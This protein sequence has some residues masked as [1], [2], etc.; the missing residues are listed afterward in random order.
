MLGWAPPQG[1]ASSSA[2]IRLHRHGE[3]CFIREGP[4]IPSR[5]LLRFNGRT[6]PQ[7]RNHGNEGL[8]GPWGLL[9]GCGWA[10]PLGLQTSHPW[11]E[12]QWEE[13]SG[14]AFFVFAGAGCD[15]DVG[16]TPEGHPRVW[17]GPGGGWWPRHQDG[18]LPSHR[19]RCM[20]LRFTWDL[21][22]YF[23][24]DVIFHCIE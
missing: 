3:V 18:A 22:K 19:Q 15:R 8:P 2:D 23:L 20:L 9:H 13:G 17:S 16:R 4:G 1:V 6:G 11:G 5:H 24:N 10:C 7:L 12:A 21:C 14:T